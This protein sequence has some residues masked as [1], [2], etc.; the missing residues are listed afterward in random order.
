MIKTSSRRRCCACLLACASRRLVLSSSTA[1]RRPRSAISSMA[2]LPYSGIELGVPIEIVQPAVVQI[3]RRKQPSVAVQVVHAG[4]E[5]HL[6]RPHAR[7]VGG[8][9]ALLEIAGRACRDDVYPGGMAA[10]RARHE[11]I[12]REVV[13][14]AAVLAGKL[15]A[16]EHV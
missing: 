11:V 2:C 6:R 1:T 16:Q 9:V 15:V 3:I 12:E 5:R 10:A 14:R 4:L 13:A 8:H 7:L